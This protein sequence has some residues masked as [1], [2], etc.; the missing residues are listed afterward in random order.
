MKSFWQNFK[1]RMIGNSLFFKLFI[2]TTLVVVIIVF[3]TT[4][5][6]FMHSRNAFLEIY[7]NS[8]SKIIAQIRDNY[9]KLYNEIEGVLSIYNNRWSCQQYLQ[10]MELTTT[11]RSIAIHNIKK[12]I[13][14]SP[15][16]SQSLLLNLIL[17]GPNGTT[18]VNQAK[19]ATAGESLAKEEYV[20]IAIQNPDTIYWIHSETG[21]TKGTADQSVIIAVK[22][23]VNQTSGECYGAALIP[24]LQEDFSAYYS[25]IIDDDI[26]NI[27]IIRNSNGV[28]LS[29]TDQELIGTVG[30]SF[31]S[32]VR[33]NQKMGY[34]EP[35]ISNEE[36]FISVNLPGFEATLIS[37]FD[38]ELMF[39]RSYD[40]GIVII[41]VVIIT[42]AFTIF[43]FFIVG[44]TTKPLTKLA[45]DM[46]AIADGD[47]SKRVEV[48]GGYEAK[49]LS[50]A[51]NSMLDGLNTYID[52]LIKTEQEK[53]IT[54]IRALQSQINPHFIYNTL[55]CIKFLVWQGNTEKTI[56]TID[57]FIS[58]LRSITSQK[59]EIISVDEE[60]DNLKNYSLIHQTR[61][62]DKI[63]FILNVDENCRKLQIPK[64]ILQPLVENAFFH[65]FPEQ[66]KGKILLFIQQ[67]NGNLICEVTDNGIGMD[68]VKIKDLV[69][70]RGESKEKNNFSG[71]GINNVNERIKLIYGNTYGIKIDSKLGHGTIVTVTLPALKYEEDLDKKDMSSDQKQGS[72]GNNRP[73]PGSSRFQ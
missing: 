37:I 11:E 47:F 48:T 51:F 58:L 49:Q 1:K 7:Q 59:R 57:A 17:V 56:E 60:I 71:L 16:A 69:A 5:A 40:Q 18:F 21:L 13:N 38:E 46:P 30:R 63:A 19:L 52:R 34:S 66:D 15:S 8:N 23:L 45:N 73:S 70:M 42:L 10:D 33:E 29:S 4:Q 27:Y 26:N 35:I 2:S 72:E 39:S 12:L 24:I 41:L 61:Y 6:T 20:Q 62:G 54:E 9:T 25:G 65:A 64:M 36:S 31:Y 68:T 43:L 14:D 22:G 67:H 53:R 55:T 3:S 32:L 28:I 50:K 44:K